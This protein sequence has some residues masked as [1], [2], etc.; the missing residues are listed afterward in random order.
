MW[1]HRRRPELIRI[2]LTETVDTLPQDATRKW[3]KVLTPTDEDED[4]RGV[5]EGVGQSVIEKLE[6]LGAQSKF[7]ELF[8]LARLDGGGAM[9]LG[10]DDG[11][12]PDKPLDLD[13][14]KDVA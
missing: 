2:H 5:D 12:K 4:G 7:A 8:H 11:Q 13:K 10:A 3:I 14:I 1:V 6:M 9:I